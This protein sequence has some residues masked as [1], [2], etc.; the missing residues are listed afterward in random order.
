MP[1][2]VMARKNMEILGIGEEVGFEWQDREKRNTRF[3]IGG[4]SPLV[5]PTSSSFVLVSVAK[6][7]TARSVTIQA[8]VRLL[9]GRGNRALQ[10][11][12]RWLIN[13]ILLLM[14]YAP[15]WAATLTLEG[16]Q[17]RLT[18]DSAALLARP[19]ATE[20]EISANDVY[21]H[22]RRYRAVPLAAVLSALPPPPGS[23]LEAAATDG[24]AAQIPL[25]LAMQA[26]PGSARAWLAIEPDDAPW[27]LLPGKKVSAGPFYI[28]WERPAASRI[29]SEYWPYQLATLRYVPAP[30]TRWPQI[31]VNASL[32]TDHPARVGQA[33]FEAT[34]LACPGM[35]GGGSSEV[36]PALT[37]PMTPTDYFQ[38]SAL[39]RYIRTPA[40]VRTWPDEKMPGFGPERL[41]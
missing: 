11:P 22:P 17:S 25:A 39:R 19:D 24:F 18:F 16:G 40:S 5:V 15:A 23:E 7:P 33:V 3:S 28:V 10:L 9:C 36:G 4:C 27:A 21:G 31:A 32:A 13:T 20:V 37:R 38:P 30:S 14:F 2:S 1:L 8:R 29:S 26:E 12:K 6:K 35:R 34:C 41:T